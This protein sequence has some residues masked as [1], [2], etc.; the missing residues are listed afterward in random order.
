M[1]TPHVIELTRAGRP[2]VRVSAPPARSR[3]GARLPSARAGATRGEVS[4][5]RRQPRLDAA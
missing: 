2:F 3:G 4:L 1:L 5:R